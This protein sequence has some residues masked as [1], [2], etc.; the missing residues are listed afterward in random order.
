MILKLTRLAD[1]DH[2]L[3]IPISM[4][5]MA[6]GQKLEALAKVSVHGQSS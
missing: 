1:K 4:L 5:W 6:G 2:P 3:S